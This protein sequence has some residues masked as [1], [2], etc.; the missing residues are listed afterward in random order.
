M[1]IVWLAALLV[2][3]LTGVVAHQAAKIGV[4]YAAK[5]LCSGVFVS[6]LPADFVLDYDIRPRLA[7]VP[8]LS[9]LL[10]TELGENVA[11]ARVF[12]AHADALYRPGYGCTLHGLE[13]APV[14]SLPDV[15]VVSTPT[16][17]ADSALD[18]I[19]EQAFVEPDNGGRNTLA[20][21]VLH[22]GQ[23]VAERYAKPV[24]AATRLQGWS[25]NKSLM[26]SFVGLQVGAGRM[27]VSDPV[28]GRLAALGVDPD[29]FSGLSDAMTL[30]H[31]M[32]M[33]S[34]L[35]FE[36]RYFPGDDVT[37]MLYG[38]SP[39]WTVPAGQGQRHPPGEFFSYSSGDTNV[40]SFLWQSSLADEPYVD[41][42]Q[43]EVYAPLGLTAP[44]LE[45][46]V[47][48][49][50]VGSSFAHLTARD[51]ARVGQWWLDAWHGRDA[52]L[53]Q[54]WQR[55]AVTPGV[56]TGYG[57]GFWLNTDQ[58]AFAGL[59]ATAFH[60]GGN[61]GQYVVVVPEAELV[62]VRLGLTLDESK[63]ALGPVLAQ[64]YRWADGQSPSVAAAP[65]SSTQKLASGN[66]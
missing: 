37:E 22:R 41:W 18:E 60:A 50:Q 20:L 57:L 14:A 66:P 38:H 6:G 49:I 3:G 5:Q 36:E 59:P 15:G 40:V 39:M 19:V 31:L 30:K 45:P 54:D 44:V 46:D 62:V 13:A 29:A 35:D 53:T 2:V 16:P 17:P 58:A 11:S 10:T 7:T 33:T 32:S 9:G 27:A 56:G 28:A 63:A 42:L 47:S 52:K 65:G 8:V 25:M 55:L 12:T 61:S 64:L 51:W 21:V 48:G 43:R 23:V 4:G 24:T 1:R 34:G 26:A